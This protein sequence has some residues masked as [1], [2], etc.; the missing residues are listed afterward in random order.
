MQD[1]SLKPKW[2]VQNNAAKMNRETN[3][4]QRVVCREVVLY[5]LKRN[6]AGRRLDSARATAAPEASSYKI[7]ETKNHDCRPVPVEPLVAARWTR[8][9]TAAVE[10]ARGLPAEASTNFRQ[11]RRFRHTMKSI[12]YASLAPPKLSEHRNC[13]TTSS[14]TSS[15]FKHRPQ[16]RARSSSILDCPAAAEAD[17]EGEEWLVRPA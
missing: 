4:T 8:S 1:A 3:S 6:A 14:R 10:E 11:T 16:S 7:R 15:N 9:E 2:L 12:R 13:A 17:P 5:L